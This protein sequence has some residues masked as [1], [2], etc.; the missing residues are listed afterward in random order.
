MRSERDRNEELDEA[1]AGRVGRMSG[2]SQRWLKTALQAIVANDE[3]IDVED[4]APA[5]APDRPRPAEREP[6]E[7][8]A[9][10]TEGELTAAEKSV[11]LEGLLMGK[12][13]IEE[14]LEAYPELSEELEGLSE[15]VEM[16]REAGEKRRKL[17]EE[18]LR[19]ELLGE[20]DEESDDDDDDNGSEDD[21]QTA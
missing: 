4:E 15:I 12:Q 9:E 6:E 17:G 11:D 2:G 20:E 1:L 3:M 13:G 14:Q 5:R 8:R 21:L 16:L 19:R 10:E 7:T 18:I